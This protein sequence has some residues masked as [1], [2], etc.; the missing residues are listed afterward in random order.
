MDIPRDFLVSPNPVGDI[1]KQ[2]KGGDKP[3]PN[4]YIVLHDY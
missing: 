1:Q 3:Y 4:K 2:R